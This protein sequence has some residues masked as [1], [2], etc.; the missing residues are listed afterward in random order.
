MRIVEVHVS[1]QRMRPAMHEFEKYVS[2]GICE[3]TVVAH[4]ESIHGVVAA[5]IPSIDRGH[6]AGVWCDQGRNRKDAMPIVAA[7]SSKSRKHRMI[8]PPK[9]AFALTTVIQ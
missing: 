5:G 1:K 3:Q 6:G 9:R 2:C 8:Q 7:A 4:A